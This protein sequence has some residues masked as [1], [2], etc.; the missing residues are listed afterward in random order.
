MGRKITQEEFIQKCK[1]VN[2]DL[3]YS[4][5]VYAGSQNKVIITCLKHGNFEINPS[6]FLRRGK[7]P[8][9]NLGI[10]T[11]DEFIEKCKQIFPRYDYSKTIYNGRHSKVKVICETHNYEF[12]IVAGD[13]LKGHGCPRCK[14]DKAKQ[15][16]FTVEEFINKAREIQGDV[17]DYSKVKYV[18]TNTKVCIICP[19]HGEFW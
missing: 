17:Y 2:P 10:P 11:N 1:I 15:Q 6:T 4:K 9:C 8:K 19:E 16:A 13:L 18:N 3:D 12:E 5:T 14:S 7:C